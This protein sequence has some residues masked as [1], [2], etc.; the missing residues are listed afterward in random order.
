MLQLLEQYYNPYVVPKQE[1]NMAYYLQLPKA[2]QI[3]PI[4]HASKLNLTVGTHP[5]EQELPKELQGQVS[6][7]FPSQILDQRNI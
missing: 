5:V 2:S 6:V 1:G 4:F 3:H 7:C